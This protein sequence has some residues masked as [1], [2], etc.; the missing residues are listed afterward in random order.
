MQ[1]G[2]WKGG[3]GLAGT[4]AK[5]R[6]H[7]GRKATI[8]I[9]FLSPS[10]FSP[11]RR[12]NGM[13]G[14]HGGPGAR[15]AQRMTARWRCAGDCRCA[16]LRAHAGAARARVRRGPQA[17]CEDVWHGVD[18]KCTVQLRASSI[19]SWRARAE[20]PIVGVGWARPR[21]SCLPHGRQ[22]LRRCEVAGPRPAAA[23]GARPLQAPLVAG[24]GGG[25]SRRRGGPSPCS[26][27]LPPPASIW[28]RL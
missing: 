9:F 5:L 7:T 23:T 18:G 10:S 14:V 25:V 27:V 19:R 17:A 21:R 8:S 6:N 3:A 15:V 11:R 12:T 13:A 26:P 1:A 28:P 16:K 22:C 4:F 24:R 2:Q 20:R